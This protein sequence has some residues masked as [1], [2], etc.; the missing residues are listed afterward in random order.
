MN[1][2]APF[3]VC[4]V[5][6]D[7]KPG[8]ENP[9]RGIAE[10]LG[11]APILKRIALRQ[12]WRTLIPFW[13]WGLGAAFSPRG[14]RLDPPWPDLLIASGRQSV[15]AALLVRQASGGRTFTVQFQDPQIS[16]RHF[17]LVVVGKHDR[18]SGDNVLA[19]RGSPCRVTPALLG[20]AKLRF[21]DQVAALPSPRVAVLIGG[22]NR[23]F[24]MTP[25]TAEAL[26]G[27]LAALC[28][29]GAGL[30]VTASR[31]TGAENEA[32]LRRALAPAMA[33]GQAVFWDGS[34]ENP[35]YGY[36]GWADA[37]VVTGDSVNMLSETAAAGLPTHVVELE[38]DSPKFR[39]MLDGFYADGAA[40]RFTGELAFWTPPGDNAAN[41]VAREVRRRAESRRLN[42]AKK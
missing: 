16:P 34:G 41:V 10:A 2:D 42:R 29:Q 15:A 20:A 3:A 1:E 6:S 28:A 17:D 27:S 21:A 7:G 18:L 38:G 9:C 12:P 39:R 24:K 14:D 25:A 37:A 31:R 23:V 30:M 8:M 32:A 36:L 5:V 35:Y 33:A 11:C 4:W 40:R 13:R 19:V 26:A 22:S